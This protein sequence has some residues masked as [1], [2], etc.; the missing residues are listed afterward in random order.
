M[1]QFVVTNVSKRFC[2]NG[3]AG[4][5]VLADISLE[6]KEGEILSVMGASGSGKST[7][8]KMLSKKIFY[9]EDGHSKRL[10]EKK[11]KNW[12]EN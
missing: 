6:W 2:K 9:I 12:E 10:G 11:S 7:L 4:Q 1:D 5:T 8:A 3:Q